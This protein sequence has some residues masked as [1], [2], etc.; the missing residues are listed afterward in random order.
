MR[1]LVAG[2]THASTELPNIPTGVCYKG[3]KRRLFLAHILR[4]QKKM[5]NRV[6]RI[7]GQVES[8]ES[9]IERG[10]DCS[11]ILHTISACRGA[12][13][14]L[15]A[16]VLDGHIRFHVIDPDDNPKSEKARATQELIDVI[17]TYLR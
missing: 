14:A 12:I 10:A 9:A 11:D 15:M 6:R 1:S 16:E 2:T 17:K 3:Q 4:D 13:N 8:I 7:R 5:L